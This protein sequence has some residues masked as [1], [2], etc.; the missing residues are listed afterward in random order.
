LPKSAASWRPLH[1]PSLK[2]RFG[3]QGFTGGDLE[4]ADA[5]TQGHGDAK[6]HLELE[7]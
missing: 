5:V 6:C 3:K 7:T 1:Q 4:K 2:L